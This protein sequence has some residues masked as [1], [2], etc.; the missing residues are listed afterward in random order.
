MLAE[1]GLRAGEADDVYCLPCPPPDDTS[2]VQAIVGMDESLTFVQQ[3][4]EKPRMGARALEKCSTNKHHRF[5]TN[6]A[7]T[8][9]MLWIPT[10][11]KFLVSVKVGVNLLGLRSHS[12]CPGESRVLGRRPQIAS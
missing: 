10:K 6:Q 4:G 5:L 1:R 11:G 9:I 8:N 12:Q 7:V 2:D 3:D